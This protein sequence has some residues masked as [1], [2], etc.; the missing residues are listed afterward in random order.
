MS[1]LKEL[2]ANVGSFDQLETQQQNN[3][4]VVFTYL[5]DVVMTSVDLETVSSALVIQNGNVVNVSGQFTYTLQN[6][7]TNTASMTVSI[8]TGYNVVDFSAGAGY[9]GGGGN[10]PTGALILQTYEFQLNKPVFT[11]ISS[12][13]QNLSPGGI[14]TMNYNFT[15][16]NSTI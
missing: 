13:L 4:Q 11:L 16:I 6:A 1:L 7:N 10:G 9:A 14:D 5:P 15:F 2:T 8:P 3:Q 12:N